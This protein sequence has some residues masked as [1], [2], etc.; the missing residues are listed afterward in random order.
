MGACRLALD[1]AAA[2]YVKNCGDFLASQN[3][4][5]AKEVDDGVEAAKL[6]ERATKI[7]MVNDVINLGN[8]TRIACFK[9]QALRDPKLIRDAQGNFDAMNKKFDELRAITRQEVNLKQ[10]DESKAA[11]ESYKTAMNELLANWQKMDE[12]AAKRTDLGNEFLAQAQETAKGGM[13]QPAEISQDA[14]S[15]LSPA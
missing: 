1:E 6:K 10:I 13:E 5:L 12:L 4:A 9:S 15:S 8:Q 2:K 7:T 3:E 11:G 14:A